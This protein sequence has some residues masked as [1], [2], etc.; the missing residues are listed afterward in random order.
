MRKL[1]KLLPE[2]FFIGLGIFWIIDNYTTSGHIN[3]IAI[4]FTWL[5]FLQLFYK[6]RVL[7]LVYGVT[8][9]LISA[10][11]ILAVLSDFY[12]YEEVTTGALSFLGMAGG[13]FIF[14]FLMAFAMVYKYARA[15]TIYNEN[16]LTVTF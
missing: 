14:G 10:Y 12:K 15:K 13:I 11:M 7:G 3:Y 6:H 1:I 9:G 8:L 4:L 2:V 5:L 16:E